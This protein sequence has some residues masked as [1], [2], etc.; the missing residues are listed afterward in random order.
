LSFGIE[1]KIEKLPE[2]QEDEVLQKGT[3]KTLLAG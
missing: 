1:N 3:L 2:L